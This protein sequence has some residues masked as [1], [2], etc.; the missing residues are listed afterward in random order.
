MLLLGYGVTELQ[1]FTKGV[2]VWET[3]DGN[4]TRLAKMGKKK[5]S[6]SFAT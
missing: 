3:T 5:K 4:G 2:R 6:I 1:V